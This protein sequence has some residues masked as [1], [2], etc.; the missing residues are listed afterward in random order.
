MIG[1]VT[2]GLTRVERQYGGDKIPIQLATVGNL[3][4]DA[5]NI[6]PFESLVFTAARDTSSAPPHLTGV[7]ALKFFA[8]QVLIE[9]YGY[10]G[11][12]R[13]L[14]RLTGGK[15]KRLAK[16]LQP[17]MQDEQR[18]KSPDL[19][20]LYRQSLVA[21]LDPN[22]TDVQLRS[23]SSENGNAELTGSAKPGG[24]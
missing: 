16:T 18:T 20:S 8:F 10:Q 14:N 23:R 24:K 21:Q 12:I 11:A 7:T 6:N 19:A 3:R 5:V 15:G 22:N 4:K 17:Y 13:E 2:I 9:R 1:R